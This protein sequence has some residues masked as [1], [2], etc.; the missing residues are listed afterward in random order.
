[1]AWRSSPGLRRGVCLL[2]CRGET[3]QVARS[4]GESAVP[5]A[6]VLADHSGRERVAGG[7]PIGR[8]IEVGRLAIRADPGRE[9][10]RLAVGGRRDPV[11]EWALPRADDRVAHRDR[12]QPCRGR[13]P[14]QDDMHVTRPCAI[15]PVLTRA[16]SPTS[17]APRSSAAGSPASGAYGRNAR[18][19]QQRCPGSRPRRGRPP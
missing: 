8:E 12:L 2:G 15:A 6:T 3:G 10:A 7:I 13:Q 5:H 11:A 18:P 19:R 17:P 9:L 1:M 16:T 14:S 4:A